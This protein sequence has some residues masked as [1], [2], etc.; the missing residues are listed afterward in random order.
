MWGGGGREKERKKT[1]KKGRQIEEEDG[2]KPDSA[3]GVPIVPIFAHASM[4]HPT[5]GEREKKKKNVYIA[6]CWLD[7]KGFPDFPLQDTSCDDLG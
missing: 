7:P 2:T 4:T 5:H 1:H 6:Y 3:G